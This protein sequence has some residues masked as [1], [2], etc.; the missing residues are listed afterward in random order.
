MAC[1]TPHESLTQRRHDS[2][3]TAHITDGS[4]VGCYISSCT[5]AGHDSSGTYHHGVEM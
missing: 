3:E 2:S 5:L 1:I 4:Q